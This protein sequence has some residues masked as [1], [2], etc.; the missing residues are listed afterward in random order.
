VSSTNQA[1]HDVDPR[2]PKLIKNI[3]SSRIAY[4]RTFTGPRGC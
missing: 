2:A 1:E 4:S 3:L